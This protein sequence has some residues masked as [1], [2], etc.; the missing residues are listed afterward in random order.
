MSVLTPLLSALVAG[1]VAW[2]VSLRQGRSARHS[3]VLDKR[4]GVYKEIVEAFLAVV[5]KVHELPEGATL[6]DGLIDVEA[7][8]RM[9]AA[10]ATPDL[11]APE[12]IRGQ[13]EACIKLMW[14][15]VDRGEHGKE[16]VDEM[17]ALFALMR[18]DLVPKSLR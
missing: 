6:R 9:L 12:R 3:W 1:V 18:E 13:A 15:V 4:F 7:R 11:V 17:Q 10:L 2:L 14:D 16:F 8:S 5:R